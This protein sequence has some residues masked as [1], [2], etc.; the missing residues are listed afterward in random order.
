MKISAT[1]ITL[2]EEAALPRALASLTCVDE[3]LVVDSGSTD[4]TVEIARAAG[5]RVVENPWPGYAQQK[6]F[7]AAHAA[8]DWILSLDADEALSAPLAVEI[9]QLRTTEPAVAGYRFPRMAQYLG[10]WIHH[11]GWYPDAKVRLYDRRRARWTG[12]YVHESVQTDGPVADLSGDLLHYTC[13]S[14]DE[15]RRTTERYTTLAAA[16]LKARGY[17]AGLAQLLLDPPFTFVKSYLLQLGFLDGAAGW[18][19]AMMAARY[20][21]L[22]YS[23]TRQ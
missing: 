5:A 21:F 14:L 2:N 19:I 18:W 4:R 3:V 17:R 15:H 13:N 1:I 16:E 9:R 12:D 22:K 6:N 7:A 23:K 10:Q 8:H 11:S 20:V